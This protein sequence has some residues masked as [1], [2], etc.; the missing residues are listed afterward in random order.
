MYSNFAGML[1]LVLPSFH[2][3]MCEIVTVKV[4]VFHL[5][6]AYLVPL[7]IAKLE[8]EKAAGDSQEPFTL[9]IP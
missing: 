6:V 5:N 1:V 9:D 3:F 7:S 4:C 2:Y 8:K